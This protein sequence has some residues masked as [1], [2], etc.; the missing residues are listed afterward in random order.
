MFCT[1]AAASVIFV[2]RMQENVPALVDN[3]QAV[4]DTALTK[5]LGGGGQAGGREKW[6]S[7]KALGWV[8]RA[9]RFQALADVTVK[10]CLLF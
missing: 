8:P 2:G 1:S 6:L 7:G 3:S 5:G 10:C 4:D 9:F